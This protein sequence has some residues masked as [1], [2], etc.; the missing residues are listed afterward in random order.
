MRE[1][2]TWFGLQDEREKRRLVTVLGCPFDGAATGPGGSAAGPAEIRRWSGTEEAIDEAGRPV[3]D[4]GVRD[5]GD[6]EAG[7]TGV[8]DSIAERAG[9]LLDGEPSVL[10]GLGGDHAVTIGLAE[11]VGRR[12]PDMAFVMFDAHADCFPDYDG[13]PESHA[14][15]VARLWERGFTT[16]E[17]TALVGLRSFARPELDLIAQAGLMITAADWR[18]AEAIDVVERIM[19]LV[20]DRPTYISIDIDVLDPAAA[21]GTGYPVAGGPSTGDL[22]EVLRGLLPTID[23][24]GLDLVE[25]S[26]PLDSQGVTAA[27][28][29]HLLLQVFAGLA[30]RQ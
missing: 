20:G 25:V 17:R 29:A 28:A 9:E 30:A 16:P 15:T 5:A 1:I 21:P 23:V 14:C 4:L 22:L 2:G 3:L 11:A 8:L 13:D 10:L 7:S 24:V 27:T 12:H 6:V 26:P 18:R 19:R